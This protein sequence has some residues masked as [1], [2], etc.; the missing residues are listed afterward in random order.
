MRRSSPGC[1]TNPRTSCG[2]GHWN[3]QNDCEKLI[4][5]MTSRLM[6]NVFLIM[7]AATTVAFFPSEM[8]AEVFSYSCQS[9][10]YP[11]AETCDAVGPKLP[12]RIDDKQMTLEWR[13][14]KYRLTVASP[15]Q[16]GCAKFGWQ[17]KDHGSS[18]SFCTATQG[19]GAIED[20]SG[21]V[22]V[23]CQRK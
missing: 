5:L 18:F 19:Y 10:I 22:R 14:K 15:D 23:Q 20:E 9:C 4:M 17:T 1:S 2:L 16:G 12:L 21:I 3:D 13:G 7:T 8:K 6:L 11:S